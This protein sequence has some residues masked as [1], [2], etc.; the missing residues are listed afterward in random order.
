MEDK[1]RKLAALKKHA[2]EL[3]P[4][5]KKAKMDILGKLSDEMGGLLG[6]KLRGLKKVTVASDSPDGLASGLDKAKE[7]LAQHGDEEN[8]AHGLD[9]E[10]EEAHEELP[11]H[12]EE[13]SEEHDEESPEDAEDSDEDIDAKIRE[14]LAKKEMRQ[15]VRI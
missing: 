2:R 15:K 4:V 14:L 8:S 10:D 12:S 7:M 1:L 5:E 9:H 13:D 6:D 11:L 3:S